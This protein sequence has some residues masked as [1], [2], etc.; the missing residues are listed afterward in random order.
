MHFRILKNDCYHWLSSSLVCTK[1][2]FAYS[3]LPD[4]L[5]GLE[6]LLLREVEKKGGE[7]RDRKRGE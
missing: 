1:Y 2:D 5:A 3:V 6:G 7:G 4:P